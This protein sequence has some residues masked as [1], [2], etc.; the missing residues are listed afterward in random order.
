MQLCWVDRWRSNVVTF[1]DGSATDKHA[2]E[3]HP[4][5]PTMVTRRG[6]LVTETRIT[7]EV[8]ATA[9]DNIM[10]SAA[11]APVKV[12]SENRPDHVLISRAMKQLSLD[13]WRWS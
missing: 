1:A 12:L 2:R 8:C 5:V 13:Q 3:K 7:G 6:V 11:D 9:V 10:G 4:A